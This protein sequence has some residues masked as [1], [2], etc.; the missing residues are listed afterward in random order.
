MI[1]PPAFF[2]K[3]FYSLQKTE[4]DIEFK[5][6]MC[7][8]SVEG[9]TL[10]FSNAY[11]GIAVQE[12]KKIVARNISCL[13]TSLGMTQLELGERINY[14]D[15][16]VSRWERADALPDASVLLKMS[17]IFGVSVDYI[18]HPHDADDQNEQAVTVTA[19]ENNTECG[20][21]VYESGKEC[22][23]RGKTAANG[24]S[25]DNETCLTSHADD[26]GKPT[27]TGS[28]CGSLMPDVLIPGSLC[29]AEV[30]GEGDY[31]GYITDMQGQRE[32]SA[33][34]KRKKKNRQLIT[35]IS[36]FGVWTAALLTYIMLSSFGIE[37]GL[38]FIY[39]IPVSDI[40]LIVLT[41]IWG[42]RRANVVFISLLVWSV[43]LSVY[44]SLYKYNMW[45]LF[46]LGIPA[47]IIVFLS[48][49][50]RGSAKTRRKSE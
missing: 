15:K 8:T 5:R 1:F 20:D 23:S 18:L 39:A 3:T 24:S 6:S 31:T 50:I 32:D 7:Y 43:L 10:V 44:L 16:A 36:F 47:Q 14:S 11:G 41:G 45:T 35:A 22:V 38:V 17:E 33:S 27:T 2:A 29:R 37:F 4:H 48:L 25:E 49:S 46:L 28:I 34:V 9:S 26:N 13:R 40:V 30:R 21:T 19:Q 12:L 42:T